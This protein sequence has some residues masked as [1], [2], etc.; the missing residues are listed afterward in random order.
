MWVGFYLAPTTTQ[1]QL[2][3]HPQS[4]LF[5]GKVIIVVWLAYRDNTPWNIHTKQQVVWVDIKI[6]VPKGILEKLFKYRPVIYKLW[7]L[8]VFHS[9]QSTY[10]LNSIL[11]H[12]DLIMIC[13]NS[14][15][16]GWKLW[17]CIE[18]GCQPLCGIMHMVN[19]ITINV[20]KLRNLL[21]YTHFCSWLWSE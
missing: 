8:C 7:R 16:E 6:C 3:L 10:S 20:E 4:T 17:V 11:N 19:K 18:R 12:S 9:S 14:S 21:P 1:E 13:A 2:T 5:N 15:A